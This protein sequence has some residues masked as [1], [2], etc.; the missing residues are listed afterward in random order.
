MFKHQ[1]GVVWQ[2]IVISA[3]LTT[4]ALVAAR[5]I[6]HD[7]NFLHLRTGELV[8]STWHVPTQDP[9][10]HT[11]SGAPWTSHEWG[12][13]LL[14][15]AIHSRFGFDGLVWLMPLLLVA[16]FAVLY[17]ELR[18]YMIPT[19]RAAGLAV[20]L[21][22][23]EAA[24][25]SCLVLRAALITSLGNALLLRFLRQLHADGRR[26]HLLKIAAVLLV[27]ANMHA[28]VTLGL[29]VIAV[30]VLQALWELRL[31][32]ATPR[33]AV[34]AMQA[35]VLAAALTLVN[36]SGFVLWTFPMRVN[37]LF[38]ASGLT[39]NMGQYR[40]P[41][42]AAYPA[43]F[44]LCVLTLGA[45]LPSSRLWRV[46]QSA[47][48]P[49]L[50]RSG[51]TLTFLILALRSNRFI[52]D[53]VVFAV[54]FCAMMWG[55]GSHA[56]RQK[57][58]T[59]RPRIRVL[60]EA[61]AAC[62]VVAVLLVERPS[63]PRSPIARS[64]PQ[65]LA[66]FMVQQRLQG[67]MFNYENFGGYLGWRLHQPVYW[68]GRN[69]IFFPVAWEFAHRQDLGELIAA[70][71]LDMLI[72]TPEL[73]QLFRGYLSAHRDT[74]ALVFW[75][76]ISALYIKRVPTF[77]PTLVHE[78]RWLQ[79]FAL[80]DDAQVQQLATNSSLLGAVEQEVQRA[81]DQSLDNAGAWYMRGRIAELR[82]DQ[83]AAYRAL[84]RSASL[85]PRSETLY[86]LGRLA[87]ALGKPDQARTLVEHVL[88]DRA[89]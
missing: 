89:H 26:R 73:E 59:T 13:G 64:I 4:V 27:W 45:C 46:L 31:K 8:A 61:L 79:P 2:F 36:P 75:D 82:G 49:A 60:S 76:D 50:A 12:F 3:A 14:L 71:Q 66:T 88:R 85:S 16:L 1:I 58:D 11:V 9:F 37:K 44:L 54:P 52:L 70:H 51:C 62:A 28:G 25:P 42:L 21:L 34:R 7:D 63:Y 23:L 68:D 53:Y 24:A 41:T 19:R 67:R 17:A 35:A 55:G 57:D 39:Y 80:P 20:L 47:E 10:T 38:Y 29:L 32:L 65:A 56:A 18:H 84:S 74:W 43:F 30:H 78:Y 83:A 15:H 72:L 40:A 86:H 33:H 22:G 6:E 48:T 77:T 87:L 81:L 5:P 69:D